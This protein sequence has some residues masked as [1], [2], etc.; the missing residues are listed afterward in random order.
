MGL[1][2]VPMTSRM[3]TFQGIVFRPIR[4]A[5]LVD[6]AVGWRVGSETQLVRRF[7]E[8]FDTVPEPHARHGGRPVEV[9]R[10]SHSKEAASEG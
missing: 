1:A 3:F 4:N 8:L 9:L 5:P 7:L 2:L 10:P 6:L